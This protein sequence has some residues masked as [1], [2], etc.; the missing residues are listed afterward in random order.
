MLICK[1][2]SILNAYKDFTAGYSS[3]HSDQMIVKYK[4]K[5]YRLTV[6]EIEAPEIT[7]YLRRKYSSDMNDGDIKI[8]ELLSK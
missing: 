3:K 4:D 1:L 7:D 8:S 2:H 5:F 6:E